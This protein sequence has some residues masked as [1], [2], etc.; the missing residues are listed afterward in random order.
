MTI[1]ATLA[2]PYW[3]DDPF[4]K[5][6]YDFVSRRMAY[7]YRWDNIISTDQVNLNWN[8]GKARNFLVSEALRIGTDVVVLCDADSFVDERA[9]DSAIEDAHYEDGIHYP[10]NYYKLLTRGGTARLTEGRSGWETMVQ[11]QGTGSLGGVF[12]IRPSSYFF[13]GGTPELEGWGFEDVMF[14]VQA[15]TFLRPNTWRQGDLYCLWHKTECRVG[16][17]EYEKNFQWYKD[18]VS[19]DN[20]KQAMRQFMSQHTDIWP[21]GDIE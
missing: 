12:A 10:F 21:W 18:L 14:A 5:K 15:R 9:L 1:K 16:S 17:P 11:D 3:G 20:N 2:F 4:R 13:S 7:A 19:F 6:A 8:R